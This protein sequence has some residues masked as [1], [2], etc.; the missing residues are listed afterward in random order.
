MG[1]GEGAKVSPNRLDLCLDYTSSDAF[2]DVL[3]ET[4]GLPGTETCIQ[5]R[6]RGGKKIEEK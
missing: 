5:L 3:D 6:P 1:V 2:F 4:E